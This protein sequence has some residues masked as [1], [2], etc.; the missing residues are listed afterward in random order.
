V[1]KTIDSTK[2]HFTNKNNIFLVYNT[3]EKS[4]LS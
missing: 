4:T 1:T 3:M 2:I